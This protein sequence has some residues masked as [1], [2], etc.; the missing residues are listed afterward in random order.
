MS[1]LSSLRIAFGA[2]LVGLLTASTPTWAAPN[3]MQ[4]MVAFDQ[5]AQGKS[6]VLQSLAYNSVVRRLVR[7][8]QGM[9]QLLQR[10]QHNGIGKA[11]IFDSQRAQNG[12]PYQYTLGGQIF[13][14]QKVM[15]I[16]DPARLGV[17]SGKVEYGQVFRN[18]LHPQGLRTVWESGKADGDLGVV[19]TTP[20]NPQGN[21][22]IFFCAQKNGKT[23]YDTGLSP[24]KNYP[25]LP[26]GQTASWEQH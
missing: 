25:V 9:T 19:M 7:T 2:C 22:N 20:H 16:Y 17:S 23:V 21:L 8:P 6:G 12:K 24:Y 26:V 4:H 18:T 13:Y 14:Y 1:K 15:V 3:N 5:I 10:A 11:I